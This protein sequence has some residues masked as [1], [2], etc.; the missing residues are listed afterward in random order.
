[1]P[2]VSIHRCTRRQLRSNV[3]RPFTFLL[4]SYIT[5]RSY[6]HV[7][8]DILLTSDLP[9]AYFVAY[10]ASS[11][12]AFIPFSTIEIVITD[13]KAAIKDSASIHFNCLMYL[14]SLINTP[15]GKYS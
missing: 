3:E 8:T 15:R 14:T 9:L 10:F 11:Q 7:L 13:Q 2:V 12:G 1:M 6:Q 4:I 5:H